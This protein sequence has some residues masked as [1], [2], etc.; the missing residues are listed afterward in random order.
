MRVY[1]SNSV[2]LKLDEYV[3]FLTR[4]CSYNIDEADMRRWEVEY[5]INQRCNPVLMK[6][7]SSGMLKIKSVLQKQEIARLSNN[8]FQLMRIINRRKGTWGNTQWKVDYVVSNNG[9]VFITSI[10]CHNM[11]SENTVH[12]GQEQIINEYAQNGLEEHMKEN[13]I[14]PLTESHIK[15]MV[16]ET[17][18]RYLQL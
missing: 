15:Q 2:V 7:N 5:Q 13:T 18:R 11:H 4:T 12:R 6:T 10:Q 1:V 8:P 3:D 9:D 17:L 16:R 14:I